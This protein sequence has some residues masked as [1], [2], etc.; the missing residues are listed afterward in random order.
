[1]IMIIMIACV[2]LLA[3]VLVLRANKFSWTWCFGFLLLGALGVA[4][5]VYVASLGHNWDLYGWEMTASQMASGHGPYATTWEDGCCKWGP[6]W[7]Y[8]LWGLRVL[9]HSVRSGHAESY[10]MLVAAFLADVDVFIALVLI[11]RYGAIPA[12]VFLLSPISVLISGYHCQFDNMAVLMALL[13]WELLLRGGGKNRGNVAV[14]ALLLGMSLMTKHIFFMF[15]LWL[16]F[17]RKMQPWWMRLLF[18]GFAFAIFF[19]SFVPWLLDP[20]LR[21]NIIN[22]TF[23][24][25]SNYGWALLPYVVKQVVPL[26]VVEHALSWVPVFSG[27]KAVWFVLML[28]TGWVATRTADR[29]LLFLYLVSVVL[30]SPSMADQY[31]AIPVVACAVLWRNPWGWVYTVVATLTIIAGE[32]NIGCLPQW[33]GVQQELRLIPVF[34]RWH[35]SQL[36]LLPMVVTAM[37]RGYR[38]SKSGERRSSTP[39]AIAGD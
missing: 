39:D 10:H 24:Y 23:G 26:S 21:S 16:L 9:D 7:G 19:A 4:L 28:M 6:V 22:I 27:M 13:S 37:V 11:L 36:C 20:V 17:W 31:L 29:D 18:G 34:T 15:P 38:L 1:M 5:R 14:A 3:G 12:S 32:W 2:A 8:V 25:S 30:F 35:L 33:Q